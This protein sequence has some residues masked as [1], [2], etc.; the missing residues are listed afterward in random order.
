MTAAPYETAAGIVG[1]ITLA[2]CAVLW[3]GHKIAHLPHRIDAAER[4]PEYVEV[5]RTVW[6]DGR[7]HYTVGLYPSVAAEA[8]RIVREA[9][10]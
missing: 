3:I 4:R 6:A 8:E 5:G 10:A 1:A 2:V 9:T 7:P